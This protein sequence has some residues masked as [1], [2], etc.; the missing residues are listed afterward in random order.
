M[1]NAVKNGKAL[2]SIPISETELE[3]ELSI[4]GTAF[5]FGDKAKIPPRITP[6]HFQHPAARGILKAIR[7]LERQ[8]EA[9]TPVAIK[10][11]LSVMVDGAKVTLLQAVG[12]EDMLVG[13][14]SDVIAPSSYEFLLPRLEAIHSRRKAREIAAE[15]KMAAAN[16]EFD[17]G[18]ISALLLRSAAELSSATKA[19]VQSIGDID[20]GGEDSGVSTGFRRIDNMIGTGGYPSGQTTIVSAYHKGGKTTFKVSSALRLAKAG[21]RVLYATFADLGGK[22]LKRRMM[23]MLCGWSRPPESLELLERYDGSLRWLDSAPI[24]IYDASALETGF[25]VETFA[26]WLRAEHA[27][28]GYDVVFIDYAQKLTTSNRK[29][30]TYDGSSYCCQM[31]ART[32]AITD[33]PFVIGSQIT[34]GANGEKTKTKGNRTWEEDAGWVLRVKRDG[35]LFEVESAY[36]RF[37][38]TG[39]IVLQWDADRLCITDDDPPITPKGSDYDPYEDQ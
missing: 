2:V 35:N 18:A 4:I 9:L 5:F 29:L 8:N 26:S 34:E 12:G 20:H 33:L 39:E 25:D 16:D 14:E 3:V 11:Q 36:S 32:A 28:R 31:L 37:G 6:E 7:A 27:A 24:Q 19:P 38:P 21:Y 22:Q 23:R 30:S 15:I 13:L 1:T 17:S 10:H